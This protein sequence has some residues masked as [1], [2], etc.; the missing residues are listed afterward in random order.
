LFTLAWREFDDVTDIGATILISEL[1]IK[2]SPLTFSCEQPI[3][4][5]TTFHIILCITYIC[6]HSKSF[7]TYW[8][9]IVIVIVNTTSYIAPLPLEIRGITLYYRALSL[10]YTA[11]YNLLS[12]IS[13]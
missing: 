2:F 12:P 5:Y 4:Q 10:I 13:S 11:H 7:S 1:L 6:L 9:V 8:V 3:L